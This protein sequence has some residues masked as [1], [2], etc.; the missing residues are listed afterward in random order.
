[1]LVASDAPKSATAIPSSD[2]I[3]CFGL[4]KRP[5]MLSACS[6][7]AIQ[8]EKGVLVAHLCKFCADPT[9]R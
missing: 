9:F 1:M 2:L 4:S 7:K 8:S 6:G 5:D 3:D